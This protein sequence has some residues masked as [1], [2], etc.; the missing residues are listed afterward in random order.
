MLTNLSGHLQN[1]PVTFPVKRV[2]GLGEVYKSHVEIL[3]L[4]AAL[5]LNLTC[6]EDYVC[7]TPVSSEAALTLRQN[8]PVVLDV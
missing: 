5:L 1:P 3:V 6:S 4:F 8:Y 2:E 7:G